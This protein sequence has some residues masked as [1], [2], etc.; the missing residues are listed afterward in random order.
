MEGLAL[1][2]N[3]PSFPF[4]FCCAKGVELVYQ[5]TLHPH[6][7]A[8]PCNADKSQEIVLHHLQRKQ[9]WAA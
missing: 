7:I 8:S 1:M 5:K 2:T 6:A 4:F 3:L 9:M